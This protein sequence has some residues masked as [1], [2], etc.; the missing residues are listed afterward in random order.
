MATRTI[1]VPLNRVEGDQEIT[2]E[3]DGD[4]VVAARCSGTMFRGFE[5]IL[6]GRAA[7]DS[8]VITPRVCG[9]CSVSHLTAAVRALESLLDAVVPEDALRVR[10]VTLMA[11]HVQCD[12]RQS[13][14]MY[15]A[16]FANPRHRRQPLFDEAVARYTPLQG[17]SA[18][19]ALRQTTK[20]LE[21]VAI[22][23]GQWPHTSFM[24]PGGIA[25]LPTAADLVLA[26]LRLQ[27]YRDW[28]EARVLGCTIER[29]LQVDSAAALD[30]WLAE[31]AAHRDGDLGF[32]IRYGRAIGLQELG[33]G[34][35][36]FLSF[37][38]LPLPEGTEVAGT[39]GQRRL[40]AA[41]FARDGH[42]EPLDQAAIAE[43]TGHSWFR[44][45]TGPTHPGQAST[46][47]Y[48]TG[49]ESDR[50]SWAKAPRYGGRA[51]ETGALAQ[52]V[53]AGDPLLTDLLSRRGASSLVRQLARIVR[54]ARLLPAMQQWLREIRGETGFY[55]S[56]P[57]PDEGEGFG[58][59][60]ASRGALG[61][62]LQVRDGRITRYQMITPTTWNA[63]PRDD[64]GNPGPIEHALVGTAVADPDDP[65]E[66]GH[67][68]RS[69][70]PCMVCTVHTVK[71]GRRRGSV[72]VA[73]GMLR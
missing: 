5:R 73:G 25:S 19:G 29:W 64:S 30:A 40:I 22:L 51:A 20:V 72:H 9:M 11:E 43:H 54:T 60:E 7:R 14:L 48:A 57:R 16:D 52:A 37:G 42:V 1:S 8:L 28:Y 65:V 18:V 56:A 36:A 63:S 46:E 21:V 47:P 55:R 39:A 61:H 38:C 3:L 4:T 66:L 32:F 24:V 15:C 17:S 44:D 45:D 58:L 2:A 53:V 70:D 23:G 33:A 49:T 10:N 67:V 31:S 26:R 35:G 68:V 59:V 69:Y 13:T 62:W 27:E 12:V 50:Y 34:N 6:V 71:R 41:G